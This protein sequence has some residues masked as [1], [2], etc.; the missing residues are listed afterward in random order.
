[1]TPV[2][3]TDLLVSIQ[4]NCVLKLALANLV[5]K[6][7]GSNPFSPGSSH[8]AQGLSLSNSGTFTYRWAY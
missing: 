4:N 2:R 6:M 7:Y 8:D 1:M 5:V 3:R